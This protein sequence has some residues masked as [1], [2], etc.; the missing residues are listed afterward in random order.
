MKKDA[1]NL[2]VSK[3]L[4]ISNSQVKKGCES[5]DIEGILE[6]RVTLSLLASLKVELK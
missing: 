2:G 4:E 5:G 6:E 3:D 1:L